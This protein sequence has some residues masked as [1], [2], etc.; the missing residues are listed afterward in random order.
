M[1]LRFGIVMLAMLTVAFPVRGQFH[2]EPIS[3]NVP[4]ETTPLDSLIH[5]PEEALKN[6]IQGTVDLQAFIDT[7][8]WA[9]E[10]KILNTSNPVFN[11]EAIRVMI[12]THFEHDP[13]NKTPLVRMLI[14]KTITFDLKNK[15]SLVNKAIDSVQYGSPIGW[16]KKNGAINGEYHREELQGRPAIELPSQV[17]PPDTGDRF[18]DVSEEPRELIPL[19]SLIQYPEEAK[20]N[21]IEGKVQLQALVGRDGS[22]EKVEILKSSDSIFNKEAIR[23]LKS[24]RFE[25][26]RYNGTPLKLWITRTLVFAIKRTDR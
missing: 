18:I 13:K 6:R 24:A 22:V 16:S 9:D 11:A 26:G 3:T 20:K 21:G 15:R 5:Y 4:F 7:D 8:G 1:I 12:T 17:E 14:S 19:E 10:I 2:E 23:V 25:P